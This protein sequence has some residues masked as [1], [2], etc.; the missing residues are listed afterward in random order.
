MVQRI[1]EFN[2]ALAE[3]HVLNNL[4]GMPAKRYSDRE[5]NRKAVLQFYKLLIDF[6]KTD[7]PINMWI[8]SSGSTGKSTSVSKYMWPEMR[9]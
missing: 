3:G 2:V 9:I 5:W 6:I 4:E 1:A 8:F 7:K